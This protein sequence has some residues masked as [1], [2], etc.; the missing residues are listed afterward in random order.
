MLKRLEDP[1][2]LWKFSAGDIKERELWDRYQDAYE[3]AIRATST[4]AAPWYVVPADRK[5]WARTVVAA[6][7]VDALSSVDLAFPTMGDQN[8]AE[9]DEIKK[10]LERGEI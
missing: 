5:W 10:R 7:I 9:L 4:D 2:K 3:H 1:K 6:I 8:K